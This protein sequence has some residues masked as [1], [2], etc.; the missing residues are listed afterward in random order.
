MAAYHSTVESGPR[1]A[2]R[3]CGS[4]SLW[5]AEMSHVISPIDL[6]VTERT[7]L[8]AADDATHLLISCT[9]F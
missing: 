6:N 1:G 2:D 3:R 8:E 5:A 9:F 7:G 4:S